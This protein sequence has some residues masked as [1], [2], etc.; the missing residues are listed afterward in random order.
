[1]TDLDLGLRTNLRLNATTLILSLYYL[2]LDLTLI[3]DPTQD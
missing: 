3:L 2:I 1:M